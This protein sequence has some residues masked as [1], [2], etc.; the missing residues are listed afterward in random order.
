MERPVDVA[1]LFDTGERHRNH[2]QDPNDLRVC[3]IV[4]PPANS[5]RQG[6]PT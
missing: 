3:D 5:A 2:G 4:N 6:A 1:S